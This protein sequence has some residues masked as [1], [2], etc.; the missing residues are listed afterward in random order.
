MAIQ[1]AEIASATVNENGYSADVSC[2]VSSRIQRSGQHLR[3]PGNRRCR[4][5]HS[6]RSATDGSIRAAHHA[7][8]HAANVAAIRIAPS[9][10]IQVTASVSSTP[11][12]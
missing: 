5:L 11:N 6:W 7:G 2:E 9:T 8:K 10:L 4:I 1:H 3:N 12:N